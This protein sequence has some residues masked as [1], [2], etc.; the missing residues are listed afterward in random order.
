MDTLILHPKNNEQLAAL[1]AIAKAWK[2]AFETE[3]SPY[4][5]DFVAKI[6]KAD[7]DIKTGRFTKIEPS[8]I[9]KLT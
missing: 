4:N 8:D 5:P 3:K 1:K 6:K 7:E 9:W 2:I